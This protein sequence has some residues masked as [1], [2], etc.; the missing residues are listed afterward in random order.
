M[1]FHRLDH[2]CLKRF[3]FFLL[4]FDERNRYYFFILF[5]SKIRKACNIGRRVGRFFAEKLFFTKSFVHASLHQSHLWGV[6]VGLGDLGVAVGD[7]VQVIIVLHA[8]HHQSTDYRHEHEIEKVEEK[9]GVGNRTGRRYDVDDVREED[10]EQAASGHRVKSPV[11]TLCVGSL[12]LVL[13]NL[14]RFL[15]V[16]LFL[17]KLG[18]GLGTR[19]SW[20]HQNDR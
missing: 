9:W 5:Y 15:F 8:R 3:N 14:R 13:A 18:E 12:D 10:T 11:F 2:L 6:H 19:R 20:E 4:K 7:G 16:H 1:D 17:V